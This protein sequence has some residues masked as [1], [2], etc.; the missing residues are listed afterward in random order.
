MSDVSLRVTS[1]FYHGGGAITSYRASS[2]STSRVWPY[3]STVSVTERAPDNLTDNAI[4]YTPEGGSVSLSVTASPDA[5]EF[6]VADTGIGIPE[7]DRPRVFERSYRVD[8]SRSRDMGGT[9]LGL[10][11][12]KHIAQLHGGSVSV[13]SRLGIGSTFTLRIPRPRKAGT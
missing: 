13:E 7:E 9:G 2:T 3:E 11:I 12:V 8:K 5:I 4:K 1:P 10:A 6:R